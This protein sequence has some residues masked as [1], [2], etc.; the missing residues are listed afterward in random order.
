VPV[1]MVSSFFWIAF[2]SGWSVI[3]VDDVN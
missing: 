2:S 3:S 1:A